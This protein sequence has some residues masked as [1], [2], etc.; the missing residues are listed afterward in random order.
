[1]R[2]LKRI[3][4]T[5]GLPVLA[6]SSL[7]RQSYTD[8][9]GNTIHKKEVQ[10]SSMK[11]SGSIEYNSNIVLGYTWKE[12]GNIDKNFT[13]TVKFLKGRFIGIDKK[14]Q[15]FSFYPAYSCFFEK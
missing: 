11:E 3:N 6:L 5:L 15:E 7:N 8:T 2:G 12:E 9:K 1:M 4:L 14:S 10:L 13:A